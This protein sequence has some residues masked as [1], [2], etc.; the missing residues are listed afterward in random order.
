MKIGPQ[1]AELGQ[2]GKKYIGEGR[3][4]V[5]F[6]HFNLSND[7]ISAQLLFHVIKHP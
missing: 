3:K 7:Q 1:A 5:F 4:M 2:K 6:L